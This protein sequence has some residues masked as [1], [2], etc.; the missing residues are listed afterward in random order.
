MNL[1]QKSLLF[2]ALLSIVCASKKKEEQTEATNDVSE[3]SDVPRSYS[4]DSW[5]RYLD[6]QPGKKASPSSEDPDV[7][8]LEDSTSQEKLKASAMEDVMIG[9]E[10]SSTEEI[11]EGNPFANSEESSQPPASSAATSVAGDQMASASSA[12]SI[13]GEQVAPGRFVRAGRWVASWFGY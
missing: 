12:T 10:E 1:F 5:I 2:L 9:D 8:P 4:K 6:S 13:P 3:S 11:V 7:S